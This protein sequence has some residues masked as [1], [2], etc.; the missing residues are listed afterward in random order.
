VSIAGI[1]S[2]LSVGDD[3]RVRVNRVLNSIQSLDTLTFVGS[4]FWVAANPQLTSC[5]VDDLRTQLGKSGPADRSCCNRGC[6][7]CNT[8][9]EVCSAGD[10]TLNGQSGFYEGA[11][12]LVNPNDVAIFDYATTIN[13]ALTI[14]SSSLPN[15]NGLE[16]LT[17]VTGSVSIQSNSGM[18]NMDGLTGLT[19]VGGD[20]YV[21]NND[22]ITHT[23]GLDNLQ[24]VEGYFQVQSNGNLT[25]LNATDLVSVGDY[26]Y[27]G[28]NPKLA[29][30]DGLDSLTTVG[31]YLTL[32]S[33][34]LL[35]SLSGLGALEHIGGVSNNGTLT[36]TS[37]TNLSICAANALR[38]QLMADGW[39]GTYSQS[40]NKACALTCVGAVCQ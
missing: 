3:L 17:E 22:A 34:T 12:T 13:G 38:T 37:H 39:I 23:A 18:L 4:F 10:A 32:T 29:N 20:L 26:I 16:S 8:M 19:T 11:V 28:S 6:G 35:T 1:D 25:T 9:T 7:T 24:T 21:Y 30:V 5:Q 14:N 15:L 27:I 36:I 33:N 2:L 40:G 31:N